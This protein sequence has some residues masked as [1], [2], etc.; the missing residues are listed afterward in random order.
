MLHVGQGQDECH[1]PEGGPE[2]GMSAA[3]VSTGR[4]SRNT[5]EACISLT[6]GRAGA[7]GWPPGGKKCPPIQFG[8]QDCW[9]LPLSYIKEG[10][11]SEV[12]GENK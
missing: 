8:F 3:K 9:V 5:K 7:A 6:Q 2:V 1:S 10:T 4:L 11:Y 12:P